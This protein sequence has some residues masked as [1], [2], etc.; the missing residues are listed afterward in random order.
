MKT[1]TPS[2]SSGELM[3]SRIFWTNNDTGDES[4]GF[5]ETKDADGPVALI[6]RNFLNLAIRSP[7]RSSIWRIF[8]YRSSF[9]V[10]GNGTMTPYLTGL[11]RRR[12][13]VDE[14]SFF[15]WRMKTIFA[16]VRI[17]FLMG[18][19]IFSRSSGDVVDLTN[20]LGYLVAT[21]FVFDKFFS[22]PRGFVDFWRGWAFPRSSAMSSFWRNF[23]GYTLVATLGL[24]HF[25]RYLTEPSSSFSNLSWRHVS[26]T[27][28]RVWV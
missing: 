9:H 26:D 1:L 5:V 10:S 13:W 28:F 17:R 19:G 11:Q 4:S 8:L 23:S 14:I 6:W 22:L 7:P 16:D 3:I 12:R 21:L 15:Q 2:L 18:T 25:R 24:G 20:F 27:C